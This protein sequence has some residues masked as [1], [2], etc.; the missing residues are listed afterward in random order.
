VEAQLLT[1]AA[2]A[3][4]GA[5]GPLIA[6]T[7]TGPPPLDLARADVAAFL[8]DGSNPASFRAAVD[9]LVKVGAGRFSPGI[10]SCL[11]EPWQQLFGGAHA[12]YSLVRFPI[13]KPCCRECLHCVMSGLRPVL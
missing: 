4:H 3:A 13:A 9:L 2:L 5:P 8:F 12:C 6:P 10:N 11:V 1:A 7:P